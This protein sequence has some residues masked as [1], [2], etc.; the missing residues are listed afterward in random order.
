[1]PSFYFTQL[2]AMALGVNPEVCHFELNDSKAVQ[3]LEAKKIQ[4]TA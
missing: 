3:L 2:L 4:V 1:V